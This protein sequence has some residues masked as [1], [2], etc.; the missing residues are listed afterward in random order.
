MLRQP[1]KIPLEFF[2]KMK[3]LEKISSKANLSKQPEE[4]ETEKSL[5]PQDQDMLFRQTVLTGLNLKLRE[6]EELGEL[7]SIF[8]LPA[9]NFSRRQIR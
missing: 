7:I 6:R 4:T 9:A 5:L 3:D 2:L 1:V 8:F